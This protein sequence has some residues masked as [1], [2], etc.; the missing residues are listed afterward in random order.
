MQ[1][2][3]TPVLNVF[4]NPNVIP[5][6]LHY[7][8]FKAFAFAYNVF[9]LILSMDTMTLYNILQYG[10]PPS[11][12]NNLD[13]CYTNVP[14]KMPWL[15]NTTGSHCKPLLLV[16]VVQNSP[17]NMLCHALMMAFPPF[18]TMKLETSL[19]IYS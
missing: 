11:Q 19:L 12:S 5:S 8:H 2:Q 6:S 9:K 17:L 4:F 16:P 3:H 10:S 7:F 14:F 13:L 1:L 18:S 15:F